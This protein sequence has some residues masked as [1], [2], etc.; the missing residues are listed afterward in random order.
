MNSTANSP[1][2]VIV[3]LLLIGFSL[4]WALFAVLTVQLYLYYQAFPND[5]VFTKGLVYFVYCINLTQVIFVTIDAF[6]TFGYGFGDPSTLNT[7]TFKWLWLV[8]PVFGWTVACIVQSFY[9][10][11]LYQLSGSWIVPLILELA[12]LGTWG[13]GIY[14]G[15]SGRQYTGLNLG[16]NLQTG[17]A[18]F[19]LVATA[20][21]DITIAGCMTYY[22]TRIDTGFRRTHAVATKLIRVSIETGV[23]TALFATL[24]LALYFGFPRRSFFIVPGNTI[25]TVYANTLFAVLNS[26]F[27]ILNGRSDVRTS[28]IFAATLPYTVRRPPVVSVTCTTT[29]EQFGDESNPDTE[30]KE[31]VRTSPPST[32]RPLRVYLL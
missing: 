2:F 7:K 1:G 4:D 23:M 13:I 25:A 26:R 12:A 22:L 28:D 27:Q 8:A 9:A 16:V 15:V 14:E 3:E 30:L 24:I 20:V 17:L 19:F 21:I 5:K 29:R 10:F 31:M 32:Y 18:V 6:D 11:R